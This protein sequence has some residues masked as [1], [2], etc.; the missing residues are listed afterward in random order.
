MSGLALGLVLAAAF[1][2]ATWNYLTKR[3]QVKLILHLFLGG[4][5][6]CPF[7][8]SKAVPPCGPLAQV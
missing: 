2:H 8:R 7:L 3:S 1:L 6:C 4:R 5:F